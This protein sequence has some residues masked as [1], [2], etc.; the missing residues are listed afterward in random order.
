M[1]F[2]AV[3]RA[4]TVTGERDSLCRVE[5]KMCT[6]RKVEMKSANR[7]MMQ[8]EMQ[9]SSLL[10]SGIREK[11]SVIS[12][13]KVPQQEGGPLPK[14]QTADCSQFIHH[15]KMSKN[16]VKDVR[17]KRT[18]LS[19]PSGLWMYGRGLSCIANAKFGMR[20]KE[21]SPLKQKGEFQNV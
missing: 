11:S 4:L 14:G 8:Q 13:F 2:C 18:S 12:V 17:R 6:F 19:E 10:E 21:H 20:T 16:K 7:T 3:A 5:F 15:E 1:T 9:E